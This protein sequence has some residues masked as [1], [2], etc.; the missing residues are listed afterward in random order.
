MAQRLREGAIRRC[1]ASKRT[2]QPNRCAD[3]WDVSESTSIQTHVFAMGNLKVL[4]WQL[5]QTEIAL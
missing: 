5:N 2:T 4:F 3:T 1:I